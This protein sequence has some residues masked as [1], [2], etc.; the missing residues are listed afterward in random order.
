MSLNFGVG[1]S[2]S[3]STF[4]LASVQMVNAL[5]SFS[6]ETDLRLSSCRHDQIKR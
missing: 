4:S 5:L 6:D 2:F 3:S 1:F